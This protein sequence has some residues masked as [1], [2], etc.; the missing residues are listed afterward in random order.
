MDA[1]AI[2]V[3][4]M[5]T[6][7]KKGVVGKDLGLGATMKMNFDGAGVIFIDG[8]STP[9]AV[10][11][12]D[13]D[14]DCTIIISLANFILLAQKK[15]NAM[16]AMGDGRLKIEGN[17]G[18]AMKLAPVLKMLNDVPE[19]ENVSNQGYTKFVAKAKEK[20]Q[21]KDLGFPKKLK[22]EFE[23]VGVVIFD[24]TAGAMNVTT[25]DAAVDATVTMTMETFGKLVTKELDFM[26]GMGQG[27][28]KVDGDMSVLMGMGA[29]M[30]RW[31]R[32]RIK[33]IIL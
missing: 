22:M 32:E 30:K 7:W 26:A 11:G 8:A 12:E 6:K 17:M 9:N 33:S 2:T 25:D 15:L 20:L 5:L 31:E 24:G 27:L 28:I 13:K 3:D 10:T 18:L 16:E 14:A 1:T 29:I 21:G 19:E 4:S 23:G